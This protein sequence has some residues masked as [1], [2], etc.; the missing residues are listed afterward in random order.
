MG[1]EELMLLLLSS[2][3]KYYYVILNNQ[4]A[5]FRL[6]LSFIFFFF[7]S[8]VTVVLNF[9]MCKY[10]SWLSNHDKAVS[11][12]ILERCFCFRYVTIL[13]HYILC[14]YFI[15]SYYVLVVK[16]IAQ[17]L[18]NNFVRIC[19]PIITIAMGFPFLFMKRYF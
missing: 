5:Y 9:L 15:R 16:K 10:R 4:K 3:L 6:F 19:S 18:A 12:G 1:V 13:C 2:T 8:S 7:L 14:H 17:G 11:F